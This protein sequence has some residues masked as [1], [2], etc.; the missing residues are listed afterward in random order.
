M[1]LDSS[2]VSGLFV[3]AVCYKMLDLTSS[4]VF[5][6][7]LALDP[8]SIRETG[9]DDALLPLLI[10]TARA[11]SGFWL[12][13]LLPSI[14]VSAIA[15]MTFAVTR[16]RGTMD[17]TTLQ[18]ARFQR[19]EELS[20]EGKFPKLSLFQQPATDVAKLLSTGQF[21]DYTIRCSDDI[22]FR[23]HKAHLSPQSH[24]FEQITNARFKEGGEN[25]VVLD[26]VEPLPMA[27]L[28]LLMYIGNDGIHLDEVYKT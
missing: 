12:M 11:C 2:T 1:V 7:M 3:F 4:D 8:F 10:I 22:T 14:S 19:S 20:R 9:H 17:L 28:L 23:V 15:F 13:D 6:I 25:E 18:E 16:N 24:Y 26:D 27:M 21:S 5:H